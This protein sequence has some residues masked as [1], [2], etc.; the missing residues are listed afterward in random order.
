M[1][2]SA[3]IRPFIL[4]TTLWL[5]VC[6]GTGQSLRFHAVPRQE[7]ERRLESGP[8]RN[9]ERE[10]RLFELFQEA[11]C[12]QTGRQ[13][14]KG[15]KL[16]N[17]LCTLPGESDQTILVGAHFDKVWAG[18]GVVDNWSGAA[19]LVSLYQGMAGRTPRHTFVFVGFTDEEKGLVGSRHFARKMTRAQKEKVT[20]MVNLDSLGLGPPN[21]WR[22][23]ADPKLVDLLFR[24]AQG[25]SV[26]VNAVNVERVGST[27]SESF[28]KRGMPAITI[29][30]I[31]QQT[32]PVI[33]SDR[34]NIARIDRDAYYQTYRLLAAYL[35]LLD[36]Q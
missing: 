10:A 11:G 18:A 2:S 20:A 19:L 9:P 35:A 16:D 32:F 22:T 29:H 7:V 12:S 6:P 15:S 24:L 31:T 30:S 5:S 33:H 17:V 1:L 26:D 25:M 21:V 27:D 4:V 34:D 14:V 28:R 36:G 8:T 13:D 23:R 3:P